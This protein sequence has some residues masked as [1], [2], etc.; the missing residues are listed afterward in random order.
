[1]MGA[2]TDNAVSHNAT[3]VTV[4]LVAA[5]QYD[6]RKNMPALHVQK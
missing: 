4:T 3:P 6:V 2:T 1:M 5:Q